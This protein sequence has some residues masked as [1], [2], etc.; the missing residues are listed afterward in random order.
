MTTIEY[1]LCPEN[2]SIPYARWNYAQDFSDGDRDVM[3]GQPMHE[4]GLFCHS[5]DKAYGLSKL[6]DPQSKEIS[7]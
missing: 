7:H 3:T 1:M 2:H 5:C 4:P 6:V